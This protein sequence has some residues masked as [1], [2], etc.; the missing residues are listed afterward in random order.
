M[1]SSNSANVDDMDDYDYDG[2]GG[3][4]YPDQDEELS[5]DAVYQKDVQLMEFFVQYSKLLHT[6][7]YAYCTYIC[8]FTEIK[9]CISAI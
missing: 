4:Y 8:I 3:G 9:I 1:F 7:E 2:G 5:T 6:S